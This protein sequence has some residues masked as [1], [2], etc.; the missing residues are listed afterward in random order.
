M[1]QGQVPEAARELRL[2]CLFLRAPFAERE[3]W[4][5]FST[6][7]NR[8]V[9]Q[10]TWVILFIALFLFTHV[11]FECMSHVC[12]FLFTHVCLSVCHMYADFI[13]A[14][15]SECMLHVC[16]CL[17]R[18]EKDIRA[19]GAGITGSCELP[20]KVTGDSNGVCWMILSLGRWSAPL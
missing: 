5:S 13:Y 2:G 20:D 8:N 12:R 6:L 11:W 9:I 1:V 14:C 16:R 19:P 4:L 17:G 7:T 15:L 10:A 3:S 18:P